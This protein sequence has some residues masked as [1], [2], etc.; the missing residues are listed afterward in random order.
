M[1]AQAGRQAGAL[2]EPAGLRAG[3]GRGNGRS[4]TATV[5]PATD[6][7]ARRREGKEA[8]RRETGMRA[9]ERGAHRNQAGVVDDDGKY[10]GDGSLPDS[11]GSRR[12]GKKRPAAIRALPA[13]F[14]RRGEREDRGEDRCTL[15]FAWGGP[16][17]RGRAR[18]D[19]SRKGA[20]EWEREREGAGQVV[21]W[22]C[23]A[24]GSRR[25]PR[26]SGARHGGPPSVAW[27][28]SSTAA[29]RQ[30]AMAPQWSRKEKF[31]TNPLAAFI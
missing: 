24:S 4:S 14:R 3:P 16:M 5:T 1:P 18:H 19:D 9:R 8:G 2:P 12:M 30:E 25:S 10:A 31:P 28:M 21:E 13:R 11:S 7:T 20:R 6:G 26:P 27:A 17:R 23:R 22:I 15:G 29:W